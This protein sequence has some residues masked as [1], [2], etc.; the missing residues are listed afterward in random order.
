MPD[1]TQINSS[2]ATGQTPVKTAHQVTQ[3]KGETMRQN[4]WQSLLPFRGTSYT[5]RFLQN[6]YH[7][8]HF[9]QIKTKSYR[10]CDAFMSY[11]EHGQKHYEVSATTPLEIQPLLLF[12][13]L[14]QLIKACLLIADP[15]YPQTAAVLAHGV[16]ARK[17]KKQHYTFFEDTIRVQKKG[18][19][20]HVAGTLFHLPPLEGTKYSMGDLL[21]RVP[22]LNRLFADVCGEPPFYEMTYAEPGMLTFPAAILDDMHMTGSRFRRFLKT[23][24]DIAVI[25]TEQN[26][27]VL[28]IEPDQLPRDWP[29]ALSGAPYIPRTHAHYDMLPE[30]LVHFLLLYN[31][32]MICRYE[33]EWWRD[34]FHH[35]SR[36]DL[37]FIEA[38]LHNT[39]EK[40]P[41]LTARYLAQWKPG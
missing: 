40:G 13:G 16:S 19:F 30:L 32:S 12:Y 8:Q 34:L 23:R 31:L 33:T 6:S 4:V 22:D 14:S 41:W 27:Q 9:E 36:N 37:S 3:I 29:V 15:A 18:L 24:T 1:L 2:L 10:N 38:F 26:Q 11:L 25:G 35:G 21:A 20:T 28:G 7:H 17:L 5:R 39:Q